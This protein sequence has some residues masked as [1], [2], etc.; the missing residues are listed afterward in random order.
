MLKQKDQSGSLIVAMIIIMVILIMLIAMLTNITAAFDFTSSINVSD[1][2]LQ[3][4]NSGLSDASYQFDQYTGL[5]M[6]NIPT[7][8]CVTTLNPAPPGCT[9]D[10][11]GQSGTNNTNGWTYQACL[12]N[13]QNAPSW[14]VINP[15]PPK[16]LVM[17]AVQSTGYY[18]GHSH[19]VVQYFYRL[20][21][22]DGLTGLWGLNANGNLGIIPSTAT[23]GFTDTD[24]GTDS[25][26]CET[27]PNTN[28]CFGDGDGD[29]DDQA[30]A[31]VNQGALGCGGLVTG[32]I[33]IYG[34]STSGT[35]SCSGTPTGSSPL[36][37]QNPSPTC[38]PPAQ[39]LPPT[40]CVPANNGSNYY[41]N[42]TNGTNCPS[43]NTFSGAIAGDIYIC[44]GPITVDPLTVSG[45]GNNGVADIFVFIPSPGGG[46][47]VTFNNGGGINSPGASTNLII[48]V[49]DPLTC[50]PPV[51][52]SLPSPGSTG[53][54]GSIVFNGHG[55]NI[56]GPIDAVLYAPNDQIN[57]SGGPFTSW[58]GN[59][60]VC[61]M[62]L[63]G[64]GNAKAVLYD[65]VQYDTVYSPWYTSGYSDNPA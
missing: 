8:F 14:C 46:T 49:S 4:A 11:A 27:S 43:S 26:N 32:Y 20:V 33:N 9:Q 55:S 24:S 60:L 17:Y 5:N 61:Y 6:A 22:H 54:G 48:N 25:G 12:V 30:S 38:P 19:S 41:V 44:N 35:G 18:N 3:Q 40:P 53:G 52:N 64:G 65:D 37:P 56:P 62:N 51:N 57:V 1:A 59:I 16:S 15:A 47:D 7:T 50:G 2:T 42:P 36:D 10:T 29:Q 39:T 45:G 58:T 63:N 28:G 21:A 31:G 13:S 23:G 34:R